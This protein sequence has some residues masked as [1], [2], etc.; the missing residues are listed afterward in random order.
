MSTQKTI[1]AFYDIYL[2]V[3]CQGR[4]DIFIRRDLDASYDIYLQIVT[5]AL[6]DIYLQVPCKASYDIFIQQVCQASYDIYLQMLLKN[7]YSILTLPEVILLVSTFLTKALKYSSLSQS[8]MSI[9]ALWD[10][11]WQSS[12]LQRHIDLRSD[13]VQELKFV[14]LLTWE[15]HYG[16]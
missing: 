11:I 13:L 15:P 14:S 12:V 10:E 5:Q 6:Y 1:D 4:Y 8:P 16:S 7:S 9:S 3:P 2:Q